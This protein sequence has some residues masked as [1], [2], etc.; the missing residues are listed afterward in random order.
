MGNRTL[1]VNKGTENKIKIL[2]DIV[3]GRANISKSFALG[4][5][6]LVDKLEVMIKRDKEEYIKQLKK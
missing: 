4:I 5:S 3:G 2:N 6:L 1:Y